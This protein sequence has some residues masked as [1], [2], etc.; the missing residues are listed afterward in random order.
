MRHSEE[1]IRKLISGVEQSIGGIAIGGTNLRLSYVNDAFAEMYGYA[2]EEMIGLAVMDL[3]DEGDADDFKAMMNQL[4]KQGSWSGKTRHIG[5][6]GQTFPICMSIT[7]LKDH[8]GNPS[9]TFMVVR[10]ITDQEEFEAKLHHTQKLDALGTFAGGVAHN[11]NNLLMAIMGNVSLV[12]LTSEPG[13]EHH[14]AL[15]RIEML[16]EKGSQLTKQ[17]LVVAGKRGMYEFKPIALDRILKK[18]CDAFAAAN[19]EIAVYRELAEDLR[20][21]EADEGQIHQAIWNLFVNAADAMPGGGELHIK[22]MNVTHKD[23]RGKVS[24]PGIGNYIRLSLE[25]TGVGMDRETKERLFDPFFSTKDLCSGTGLGLAFVYGVIKAHGGYID[26]DSEKGKGT[27][28]DI[29]LPASNGR[30]T[31]KKEAEKVTLQGNECVLLVDDEEMILDVGKEML[32]R[33]GYEVLLAGSGKEALDIYEEN[34]HNIALIIL[35]MIMPNMSGGETYDGLREQN[36]D[37]K[38]LLSSGYSI[39][40]Q[41]TE[42]LNRGCN[43]FI[44]KPFTVTALSGKLREI[45]DGKQ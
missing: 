38:V 11:F 36:S 41:A 43:G 25:D 20:S 32:T 9:G 19:D 42:I 45:L 26:I 17:L 37:V 40:G 44:Q 28:I 30:P 16:V 29:Y 5:K 23:L 22:S 13:D 10:D 1:E 7:S 18:A 6:H 33:L 34:Q 27:V 2:P 15:K 24:N 8:E 14:E 12:L 39:D 3:Q 31:K 21:I 35:D 4:R